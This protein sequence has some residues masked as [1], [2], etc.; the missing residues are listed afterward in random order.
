MEKDTVII[1]FK[2]DGKEAIVSIENLTKANKELREERKKLD[3][4]TEE[5]QKQAREINSQLDRNTD[6]IKNNTSALEKQRLNVGNYTNSIKD[7]AKEIN[8]AGVNVG[9]L[10]SKF[11]TLA[12][13]PLLLVVTALGLAFSALTAY[14]KG[15]E[16]GQDKLAKV[17]AVG[18]VVMEQVLQVVEKLG[19]ALLKVIEFISDVALSVI[20]RV[21]PQV[22]A[23]LQTAIAAGNE[24]ADLQD[25]I[26]AEENAAIVKRA[27]VNKKVLELREKAI[28]QEGAQK[29][30]TIQ[31]AIDL[32]KGLAA[33]EKK[34][35]EDKLKLIDLENKA[36]GALTE[37][38]KKQ[39]AEALADI[40]NKESEGAQATIKFQKQLEALDDADRKKKEDAIAK[41][42]AEQIKAEDIHQRELARIAERQAAEEAR[43]LKAAE[44]AEKANEL[45]ENVIVNLEQ[46]DI[47]LSENDQKQLDRINKRHLNE[48]AL[49]K[50]T[51]TAKL[52]IIS[53]S[54]GTFSNIVGRQTQEGKALATVQALVDT[55]AGANAQLKLPFPYNAIAVATT[56]AAGL[57]NVA[58]IQGFKQ[59][60]YTGDMDT[61]QIAGV[62]HGKEFVMPAS[63]VSQ[64][65]K[66]HFQ[67]Y[68]DGSIV[69]NS[70]A[71]SGGGQSQTPTVYLSYKEFSDF[72]DRVKY[73]EEMSAA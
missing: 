65:G 36:T 20:D 71:A 25:R 45:H 22:G 69:A 9:G 19:E 1:D 17:M 2:V 16:E 21:A 46:E 10:T 11:D 66:D 8:I 51:E 60:G 4:Q 49:S 52:G 68:M 37:E 50:M 44:N 70:M 26:E 57:V 35:A 53:N 5:G 13:S 39:R 23:A 67:S 30:A 15:S 72:Q 28:K 24:I 47:V 63:V 7:A 31:E 6:I 14:F 55:Y 12:K 59:G 54:A 61:N 29:R 34:R 40:I 33:E 56:I 42:D 3:L 58:K 43:M 27:E 73:K 18:K 48:I 64:F 32:E 62:T 41:Q 38:Q